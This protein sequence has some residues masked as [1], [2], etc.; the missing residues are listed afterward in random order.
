MF[1]DHFYTH[2]ISRW[3]PFWKLTDVL[4]SESNSRWRWSEYL[5]WVLVPGSI[6]FQLSREPF[7]LREWRAFVLRLPETRWGLFQ[8]VL[9]RKIHKKGS[10]AIFVCKTRHWTAFC[11][12]GG[13]TASR[14]CRGGL[15]VCVYIYIWINVWADNCCSLRV[16][17][18]PWVILWLQVWYRIRFV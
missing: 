15:C 3:P 12:P 8:P 16:L 17:M 1:R 13:K 5:W 9:K 14:F 2:L 11:R 18:G 10:K 7:L 4:A 6:W